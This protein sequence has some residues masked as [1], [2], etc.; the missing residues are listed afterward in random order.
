MKKN[1]IQRMAWYLAPYKGLLLGAL[2]GALAY[3]PLGLLGPVFIG[4]AIDAI[5]GAG[6][7]DFA[8]VLLNLG[9]LAATAA[10]SALLQWLMMVCT[11]KASA[12]AAQQ[13]RRQAFERLNDVPLGRIDTQP[14]GDIVSRLVNDA[15]NVSEGYLQALTQLFPSVVTIV[16]TIVLMFTLN[17]LIALVVIV[18]T[19]L[20]ILFARLVTRRTG[21]MFLLQSKAQGAV[22]SQVGE[23]VNNQ[24]LLSAFGY[25]KASEEEFD[26]VNDAYFGANF[27]AT[28]YS[29]FINPGTRYVNAIVYAAVGVFGALLALRGGITVG[30]I[31]AFLAYANQYTKPFNEITAV[32]TQLQAAVAGAERLF[33]VI[34][35]PPETPDVLDAALPSH[36]AG[37]VTAQGVYFSY[38]PERKLIQDFNLETKPGQRIALVGPTGCGKT[39]IINLLM[40]FYD[41]D[42]GK[43]LVD[44]VPVVGI[45][46]DALRGLYG[47]VLQD[48]WLKQATV[49][50]NIAYANPNATDE[51]VQ[52]AAKAAYAHR[53]IMRLPK[54]YDTVL[55][56]GGEGLSAGQRQLLCIA[57]IMLAKPDMLILDEATSSIDT[58][59]EML[60]QKALQQLME[61]HT[62]FIVAHRLS[63]I[64]NADVILVMDAGRII[65]RG[66]HEELLAKG[67][68]YAKLYNSQFAAQEA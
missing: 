65:E 66:R 41:V 15:D 60:I 56:N 62:S 34:D 12:Y 25:E 45:K 67:G 47:M 53:F 19:P 38:V 61:G 33:E 2:L 51:E 1:T 52:A 29:S 55:E 44:D 46:R 63:T 50:E 23:A 49:R 57:R 58:R 5:A 13:M 6:D 43:I 24:A 3:V 40:R 28:V 16:A 21:K 9:W 64:Q 27:K 48:T 8:V 31:S 26:A 39:T 20:S 35:W 37:R 22:S 10:A 18:A 32:F 17:A 11:R 4:R 7:V 14:H 68:F 42:A 30:G 36:S 59:T 54:G